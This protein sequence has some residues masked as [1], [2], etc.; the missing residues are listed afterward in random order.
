VTCDRVVRS[1][2]SGWLVSIDGV[3]SK[4]AR[5]LFFPGRDARNA[6]TMIGRLA[7]LGELGMSRDGSGWSSSLGRNGRVPAR[8]LTEPRCRSVP[9][10]HDC[11]KGQYPGVGRNVVYRCKKT[12]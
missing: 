8:D 9:A 4:G 12:S 1:G 5:A 7:K 2:E 6:A 10:Q 3:G 11:L